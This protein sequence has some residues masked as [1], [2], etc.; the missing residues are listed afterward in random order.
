[1]SGHGLGNDWAAE[2]VEEE[3]SGSRRRTFAAHHKTGDTLLQDNDHAVE[4]D[5]LSD[6]WLIVDPHHPKKV[7][8]DLFVGGRAILPVLAKVQCF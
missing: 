1:M 3:E 4:D 7:I 6:P 8:W 5:G 2:F